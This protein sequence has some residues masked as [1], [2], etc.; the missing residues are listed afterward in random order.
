M[1]NYSPDDQI[2]RLKFA[3]QELEKERAHRREKL[4]RIFSWS[5]TLL[6]AI[7][8]GVVALKT[9]TSKGFALSWSLRGA[10]IVCVVCLLVF[11]TKWILENIKIERKVQDAIDRCDADLGIE[12]VLPPGHPRF[13]PWGYAL[14]LILL[15][16][17][18]IAA[19]VVNVISACDARGGTG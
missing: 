5:G 19:I 3:R 14:A 7:T 15:A 1:T 8:G 4:W 6:I 2:T 17:A 16:G 9:D 18:A 11:S 12:K 10:L 13:L